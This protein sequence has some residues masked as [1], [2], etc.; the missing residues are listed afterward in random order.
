MPLCHK[1][2]CNRAWISS[3][4]INIPV[5]YN[6]EAFAMDNKLFEKLIGDEEQTP[7]TINKLVISFCVKGIHT[8]LVGLNSSSQKINSNMYKESMFYPGSFLDFQ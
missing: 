2:P 6:N 3:G 7:I 1:I 4:A 5:S 8:S